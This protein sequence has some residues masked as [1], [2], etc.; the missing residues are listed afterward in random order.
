MRITFVL[1]ISLF[2]LNGLLNAQSK[3]PDSYVN[4]GFGAGMNYGFIGIKTVVGVKNSGLL[5]GLGFVPG[6][7]GLLG[8]EIGAQISEKW[9]FLNAGYGVSGFVKATNE[10]FKAVHAFNLLAGGMIGL[11]KNKRTFIDLG[12][13]HTFATERYTVYGLNLT[14]DSFNLIIGLG[15]RLGTI[16]KDK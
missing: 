7:N 6:S 11:G 5:V 13:G 10:D 12:L 1:F 14:S 3:I 8:Y 9:F 15:F 16:K 4:I 2:F